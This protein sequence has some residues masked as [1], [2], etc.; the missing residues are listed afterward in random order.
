MINFTNLYLI[1]IF[2]IGQLLTMEKTIEN[3]W[4]KYFKELL[5]NFKTHFTAMPVT[6]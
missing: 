1:K 3:Q 2:C 4:N 6:C 5:K